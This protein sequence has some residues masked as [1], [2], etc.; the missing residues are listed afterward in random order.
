MGHVSSYKTSFT[1]GEL[2]PDLL[3]RTDLR[4]YQNGARRLRNVFVHPTGGV[5]RR[6][7]L[8][9]VDVAKGPARLIT[10]EFNVDQTYLIVLTDYAL[11]VYHSGARIAEMTTPWSFEQVRQL[12][13]TQSADTLLVVHPDVP[14]KE[15]SRLADG[16]WSLSDWEITQETTSTRNRTFW[17]QHKFVAWNVTLQT[18]GATGTVNVY[19]NANVFT[20]QHVGTRFR[21]ADREIIIT[22]VVNPQF[23]Y[24]SI[25]EQLTVTG[26]TV[27][28]SEQSWSPARGWPVSV[29]FHQDRL[30][31]G[32]S[33]DLPNRLWMSRSS[34]IF[35][36]FVGD[37]LDDEAID[38]PILSD[39]VNAVRHVFSGR[40]LQVF[41][42]GAEW[43]VSGDPLTP[44]N[45]QV[46]RQTRVGSPVDRT[47]PPRDVD[48]A[49]LFVPRTGQQLREFIYSDT[50]Q[51]Y[52]SGDTALLAHHLFGSPVAMDYDKANRLFHVLMSEGQ[53]ATLTVYRDEDVTAW[54][55]LE[56]AGSFRSIA[57]VGNQ[58][59]VVVEREGGFFIEVFDPDLFVDA[60]LIGSSEVPT[61]T[62][63]G[64]SHLEGYNVKV[65]ANSV[66]A[67]DAIV[68]DGSVV[69][70]EP[71]LSVQAGLGFTH[72]VE[73]LPPALPGD[74]GIASHLRPI[75]ITF[76]VWDT[77]SLRL[78]A[79]Q[80]LEDVP[81]RRL[82]DENRLDA[83]PPRFSGDKRIRV[84]GWR[85]GGF[86]PLWRIE[87]DVPTPFTLLSVLTECSVN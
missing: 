38:F 6:W 48:G 57:A 41:T 51:A 4:A 55:L 35:N 15:L 27:D 46:H 23:A 44:T 56:T 9:F 30:V 37:A 34:D 17:P 32:G 47:I 63:S 39:Q 80:G 21:I 54:S 13:W 62:W 53:I 8:R 19:A 14:P 72:V 64:L 71:A 50:E 31:V 3:G 74:A 70:E 22:G 52:R 43:M 69:L 1:S 76:R 85:Q 75:A 65:V 82:G 5:F 28:W 29:C 67:S 25:Q 10:F 66:P 33:R 87:Q 77:A 73:P 79:G 60:G 40:H 58:M 68:S 86:E 36:F 83:P 81:F 78:D 45:I 16:R 49:T 18:T 26:P 61:T 20:D 11:D 42:S 7:G 24:A 12:N 2:S 59:F 84:L